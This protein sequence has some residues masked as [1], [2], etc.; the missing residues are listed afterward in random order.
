MC[1]AAH[2]S[3]RLGGG[4]AGQGQIIMRELSSGALELCPRK[5]AHDSQALS[6]SP[7][8]LAEFITF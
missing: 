8:I 1:C 5:K 3:T 2:A 6:V 4:G 7:F